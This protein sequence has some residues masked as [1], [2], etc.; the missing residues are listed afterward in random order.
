V[1]NV[2]SPRVNDDGSFAG[3]IG[4]I[5][6]ITDQKLAREAL[7]KLSGQLIEA[8]ERERRRIARELHDDICQRLALLSVE[9]GQASRSSNGATSKL[10]EIRKHCSEIANDLQTLSHKLHSSKLDYLGIAP[11]LK[12]FCEEFSR[13]HE[14]MVEF[15]E[16]NVP[17]GVPQDASLCLFR[18]TQEALRNAV[19]YSRTNSFA[20]ELTGGADEVQLEVRDWGAGFDLQEARRNRGLGLISMRE[21]VNLVHGRFSIESVPGEGTRVIAVVPLAV[22]NG[23]SP[24]EVPVVEIASETKT[25]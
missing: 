19:K 16:R 10:E 12:G 2:A 24:E 5:I 11:A 13:Q 25:A 22:Q 21:R 3:F 18:V 17:Q 20:V 8:Q 23:L 4:S 6:D 15:R 14:V 7:Q 9:L 1:F